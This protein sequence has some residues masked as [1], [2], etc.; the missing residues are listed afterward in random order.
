MMKI[1]GIANVDEFD[2]TSEMLLSA[3]ADISALPQSWLQLEFN[4]GPILL[5]V[6][7]AA[8]LISSASDVTCEAEERLRA[9]A[10]GKPF[11]LVEAELNRKLPAGDAVADMLE[12]GQFLGFGLGGSCL[13]KT[14]GDDTSV[15]HET[16]LRTVSVTLKPVNK[17]HRIYIAGKMPVQG[18][19]LGA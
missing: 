10:G 6:V 3:G 16:D 14:S 2:C 9:I 15:L 5:G 11:L 19:G 17:K 4:D 18:A 13:R 7:T 1:Y 8:T 12:R